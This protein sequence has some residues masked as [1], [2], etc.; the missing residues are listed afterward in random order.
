MKLNRFT[1]GIIM[2]AFIGAGILVSSQPVHAASW[3]SG[4]PTVLRGKWRT[5]VLHESGTPYTRRGYLSVKSHSFNW[6]AAFVPDPSFGA[7]AKYQRLS[8]GNY[9]IAGRNDANA[10]AGGVVLSYHVRL[11]NRHKLYFKGLGTEKF[12]PGHVYYKY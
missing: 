7:H 12:W 4:T 11:Y 5:K 8:K 1:A 9:I 3:H 10:P 6:H 2:T